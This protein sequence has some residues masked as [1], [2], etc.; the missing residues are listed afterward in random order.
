MRVPAPPF[1][2]K[3]A[4]GSIPNELRNVTQVCSFPLNKTPALF[5]RLVVMRNEA[6]AD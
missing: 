3:W 5:T 1:F 2:W 4:E 6:L